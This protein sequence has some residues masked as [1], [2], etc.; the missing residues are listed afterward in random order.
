M[1]R[2]LLFLYAESPV[3]AGADS[4]VGVVDL[5]I[6]REASTGLPVIWGQS[7][8]GALREHAA[9]VG[10]ADLPVERVF[11]SAPSGSDESVDA[12]RPG[13][14]SVGDA[15]LVAMPVPT[16]RRTFAWVASPLT[17]GRL[18]RKSALAATGSPGSAVP[19]TSRD[20][21]TAVDDWASATTV[22]G[23]YV[24]EVRQDAATAAWS[25]WLAD[26]AL[27][28][29]PAIEFFAGKLRTDLLVV[30]DDLMKA[31]SQECTEV[32]ARVQLGKPDADG[33]PTKT[34]AHGP[35]YGEYLPA[36]TI[37]A[38]VLECVDAAHLAALTTLLDGTILRIGGDET[39]GKGLV[40]CRVVAE[41]PVVLAGTAPASAAASAGVA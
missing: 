24:L 7:L 38:A 9:R 39:I 26:T 6:Q 15:Q 36:E 25:R 33:N 19:A 12:L 28:S 35:F 27:P 32:S 31:L 34:V 21:L 20:G 4:S 18:W 11:G 29:D 8:K 14:L 3:H 5:P 30:P 37:L 1:P 2:A 16:L 22:L 23:P 40:W 41:G 17:L 10:G 13:S